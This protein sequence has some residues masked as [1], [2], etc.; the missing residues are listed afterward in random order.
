MPKHAVHR[1]THHWQTSRRCGISKSVTKECRPDSKCRSISHAPTTHFK[2]ML[3]LP[4][5]IMLRWSS[6]PTA[7]LG[8]MGVFHA[9]SAF[10]A[11][12]M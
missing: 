3:G 4:L 12:R 8:G 1:L 7:T 2:L 5:S 10:D 6:C 11:A 9:H